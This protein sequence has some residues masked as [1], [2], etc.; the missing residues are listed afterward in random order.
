MAC[1]QLSD[2][3]SR[4]SSPCSRVA[5]SGLPMTPLGPK[6]RAVQAQAGRPSCDR[7]L[8]GNTGGKLATARSMC[9]VSGASASI[10]AVSEW[11]ACMASR[12]SSSEMN[13]PD[14]L[15]RRET[16]NGTTTKSP[17]RRRSSRAAISSTCG[18]PPWPLAS[19]SLRKPARYTDSP[20]SVTVA[21]SVGP[22]SVMVPGKCRCSSDLP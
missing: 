15:G 16:W 10:S 5:P 22:V 17:W 2:S 7:I 19:S 1:T 6:S 21:S 14:A 4:I 9:T 8:L 13:L 18:W 3:V 12:F 11:P 20:I